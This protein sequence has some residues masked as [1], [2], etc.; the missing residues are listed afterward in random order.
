MRQLVRSREEKI[1]VKYVVLGAGRQGL[2]AAFDLLKFSDSASVSLVDVSPEALDRGVRRLND[3]VPG[4]EAKPELIDVGDLEEVGRL[5]TSA[6]VCLSAVPY[7]MNAELTRVAIASG[8][9]FCDLGGNTDVVRQ[10]LAMND[11]A[12]AAGVTIVPDCGVGPGM[13]SNLTVYGVE[14]LDDAEDVHIYDGG[15]LQQPR[16]PFN[17]A[18]VFNVAGLTNEYAGDALYLIDGK[19]TP[20]ST[21]AEAE[22]ERIQLQPFGELEAFVTSGALSTMVHTYEGRLRTLK[23]KTLR[24]PG[25]YAL[26]K[27]L[28]DLG[29]FEQDPVSVGE[30]EVAPRAVLHERIESAMPIHAEDRDAMVIHIIVDGL[31]GG[32][33][34]RV[35]V[36]V[37]DLHDEATGFTGMERTTGFHLAIV[38]QLIASGDIGSG[39]IPLE[40][41]VDATTIVSAL[42]AR[43]IAVSSE[44]QST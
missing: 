7:W 30:V 26:F 33:P 23:N 40:L 21:F 5:L 35:I 42:N 31:K 1:T 14:Q 2:A 6:D 36:D 28:K 3:L 20:V 12:R 32:R 11:D 24:Y 9:S 39:A 41:A 13:I 37:C 17:Y 15:L 27:G 34:A 38:A 43:G 4:S 22:Y 19:P 8:C 16:P 10:Q 18:L 25:H 44:L 29:F